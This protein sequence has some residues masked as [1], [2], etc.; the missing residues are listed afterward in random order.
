MPF[1]GHILTD[2]GLKVDASKVE[3]A[4]K[5]PA[6]TDIPALKRILGMFGYLAK[7]LPHLSED[8]NH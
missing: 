7:F 3:A 6:T 4:M 5:M 2:E 1:I 8:V